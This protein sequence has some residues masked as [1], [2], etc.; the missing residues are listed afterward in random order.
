MKQKIVRL[1]R[2]LKLL[3]FAD[4]IKFLL[5]YIGNIG[6]NFAFLKNNPHIRV[7]P[8][9]MLYESFGK[10]NYVSYYNGGKESAEY[11][12]NLLKKHIDFRNARICEWGC[13][14]SRL[15][16]HFDPILKDSS[17]ELYGTDYNRKSVR[18]CKKNIPDVDFKENDLK[19]PLDFPDD[20]FDTVYCISVLTH[21]SAES[22]EDW[23]NECLRIL[24]P[25]GVF[26]MTVH[27]DSSSANLL[28]DEKR[29]YQHSGCVVRGSVKE[30]QRNFTTYNSSSYM[31]DFLL[32]DKE[33][34]EYIQGS[35]S[36]VQDIW[37]IRKH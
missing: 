8:P 33:I 30:G 22:Q 19:P 36:K 18:W 26:L 9:Y 25:G 16:R 23:L 35:T 34:L 14:P 21:L 27:G 20:Y 10:C 29:T 13:G 12:V 28:A 31:R 32:K 6:D 5:S 2:E 15:L 4:Y 3:V 37:I 24:R 17:T 11:I 7:P 1:L